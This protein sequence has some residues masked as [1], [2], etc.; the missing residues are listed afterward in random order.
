MARLG[1]LGGTFN[2]PHMGHLVC[3]QEAHSQLGLD[4]VLLVPVNA[5]PETAHVRNGQSRKVFDVFE[6]RRQTA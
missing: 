1:I 4:L 5:P 3:A 2:P 6:F